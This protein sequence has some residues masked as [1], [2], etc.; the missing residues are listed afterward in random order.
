MSKMEKVLKTIVGIAG[1]FIKNKCKK[2]TDTSNK[3]ESA[4]YHVIYLVILPPATPIG[5]LPKIVWL[6]RRTVMNHD[7]GL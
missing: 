1:Q 5:V 3:E 2:E 7:R 6:S 4:P